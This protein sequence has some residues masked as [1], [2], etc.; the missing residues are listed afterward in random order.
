MTAMCSDLNEVKFAA[1]PCACAIIKRGVTGAVVAI[2]VARVIYRMRQDRPLLLPYIP[3]DPSGSPL[4]N[5]Q[6]IVLSSYAHLYFTA[7]GG[8][9]PL[10][11]LCPRLLRPPHRYVGHVVVTK[12]VVKVKQGS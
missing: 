10:P 6:G 2:V 3:H 9:S 5:S 8:S 4:H 1:A 11:L 7:G 12:Y